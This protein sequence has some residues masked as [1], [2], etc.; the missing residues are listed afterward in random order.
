MRFP[1]ISQPLPFSYRVKHRPEF[2]A[3]VPRNRQA[4]EW[5]FWY[6]IL[7]P[8]VTLRDF[9]YLMDT[10]ANQVSTFCPS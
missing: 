5:A 7:V 9:L 1:R 2:S 10:L 4:K 6:V 8:N 3:N